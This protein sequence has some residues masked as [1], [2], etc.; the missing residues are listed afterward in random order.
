MTNREFRKIKSLNFLYEVSE[1]GRIVRNSRSKKCL[2]AMQNNC[3]Y[4]KVNVRVKGKTKQVYIHR[5]VAECWLGD[6][7][8]GYEVDHIDRNKSNNHYSNLRYVTRFDNNENRVV[9]TSYPVEIN[10]GNEVRYFRSQYACATFL[11]KKY[12]LHINTIKKRLRQRRKHIY[13]YDIRY[14]K[15]FLNGETG[16]GDQEMGKE[17]SNLISLFDDELYLTGDLNSWNDAKRAEE[18]ERIKHYT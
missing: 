12:N 11:S 2:N 6:C 14:L 7:P 9:S 8:K 4:W 15:P 5:L 16:H 13:D 3:G 18:S 1:D 17:Q 10:N